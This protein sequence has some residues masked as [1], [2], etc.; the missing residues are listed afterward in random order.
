APEEGARQRQGRAPALA[1]DRAAHAQGLDRAEGIRRSQ[2]RG[3]VASAPGAARGRAQQSRESEAARELDARLPAGGA[4]RRDG[5]PAAGV[6][7]A[8]AHRAAPYERESAR[9]WW[10]AAQGAEAS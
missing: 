4:V 3:F 9:Q 6:A 7:R 8:L 5:A 2:T 1:D 10:A